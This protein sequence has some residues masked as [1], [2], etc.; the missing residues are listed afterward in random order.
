MDRTGW[1]NAVLVLT[2]AACARDVTTTADRS[3]NEVSVSEPA[4]AA[5]LRCDS[6][7]AAT[8]LGE[9]TSRLF[10]A[11]LTHHRQLE[12]RLSTAPISSWPRGCMATKRQATPGSRK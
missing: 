6:S 1:V 5:R 10:V 2:V 3:A 11:L 8:V 9:T 7:Q 12:G 4:S